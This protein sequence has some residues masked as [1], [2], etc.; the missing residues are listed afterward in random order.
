ME[1]ESREEAMG[2][3]TLDLQ[4]RAEGKEVAVFWPSR[5]MVLVI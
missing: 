5:A 4:R 3:R 2:E 1:H